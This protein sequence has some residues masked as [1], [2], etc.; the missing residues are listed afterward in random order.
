M[1]IEYQNKYDVII[2]IFQVIFKLFLNV[3][4]NF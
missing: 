3:I 1:F 4:G 2:L